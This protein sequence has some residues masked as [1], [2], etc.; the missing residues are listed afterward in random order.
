MPMTPIEPLLSLKSIAPIAG[1]SPMKLTI[2]I[3]MD[4]AAFME[5][6]KVEVSRIIAKALIVLN[7]RHPDKVQLMD[8]NGN[9]VGFAKVTD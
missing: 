9:T 7:L 4:N 8:I 2:E 1:R 6:R 5:G 3:E